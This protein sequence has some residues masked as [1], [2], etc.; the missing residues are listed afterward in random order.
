M[1]GVNGTLTDDSDIEFIPHN[2]DP[3]R[4]RVLCPLCSKDLTALTIPQREFH[5]EEEH[6][7]EPQA[8]GSS[9]S[10]D[11][12]GKHNFPQMSPAKPP[13]RNSA[14]SPSKFGFKSRVSTPFQKCLEEDKNVFWHA[15][16]SS[17]PPPNIYPGFIPVLKKALTRSHDRG[18]TERAWLAFEQAVHIHGETW[19]AGWGCGYRNYLMACAALM[20]QQEQPMYFPLLD[21]PVPP[22]IR[23]LQILLERAWR[24]GYDDE[25]AAQLD[26]RLVDTNK[27]IGTS[28]LYVAF[29]FRGIPSELVDFELVGG[30]E[31]LLKWI[32]DYFSGGSSRPKTATV[33]EALLGA[34]PIIVTDK[35]PIILQHK[36]HSRTI[37][38]Y[39][40]VKGGA[41]N[42]LTFDPSCRT[43]PQN[44]RQAGSKYH[45]PSRVDH[46]S[47]S[48]PARVLHA[49]M[50]PVE[51]IRLHK[52]KSPDR[53]VGSWKKQR[54]NGNVRVDDKDI[55][56]IE[57]DEDDAENRS[58]AN[59][60]SIQRN[61]L[62]VLDPNEVLKLFRIAP[63]A[64]RRHKQYQI[65]WFPLTD[66][67]TEEEKMRRRVVTS[68]K[69]A[70]GR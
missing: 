31:P 6:P 53:P 70:E 20:D 54:T 33:S 60:L 65:L 61:S 17:E 12:G 26:R 50:H 1:P 36:G 16:Q 39:E 10:Q 15:S 21:A 43:I 66:P 9:M 13:S 45:N 49:A 51:T 37:V 44:I 56:V 40:Q 34:R 48:K 59:K 18:T 5:C 19:D 35:I 11:V 24:A 29:T 41:I 28:D 58:N 42:L 30:V 64:L 23:N 25:G 3:L 8:S 55:I 14:K 7:D 32:L 57:D 27:W 67:L 47:S 22:G 69:C 46:A 62:D 63:K 4:K 2:P 52:R 38:G 68:Q